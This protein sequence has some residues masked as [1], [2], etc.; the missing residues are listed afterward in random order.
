MS[1]FLLLSTNMPVFALEEAFQTSKVRDYQS[2]C[3]SK[4]TS[5]GLRKTGW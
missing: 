5:L 4:L 1:N 3:L 2:E